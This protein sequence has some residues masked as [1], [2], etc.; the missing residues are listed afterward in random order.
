MDTRLITLFKLNLE[1]AILTTICWKSQDFMIWVACLG[2][3][4]LL[5]P[6]LFHSA[7]VLSWDLDPVTNRFSTHSIHRL[8]LTYKSGY[9][10]LS[11]L[12]E[13]KWLPPILEKGVLPCMIGTLSRSGLVDVATAALPTYKTYR[14]S[15]H[16]NVGPTNPIKTELVV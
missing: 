11:D 4:P 14:H 1:M 7:T 8:S 16:K 6:V 12:P 9:E 10:Q 13:G 5:A 3:T 2:R 15:S